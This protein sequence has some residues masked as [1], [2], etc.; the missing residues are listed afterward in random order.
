M[1]IS[2]FVHSSVHNFG[3][4]KKT[5]VAQK[6]PMDTHND[7]AL[8]EQYLHAWERISHKRACTFLYLSIVQ[9]KILGWWRKLKLLRRVQWILTMI[10]TL[11]EQYLHAWE[12]ISH[13]RAC[14]FLYLALVFKQCRVWG[15][16]IKLK[17]LRWVKCIHTMI[18]ALLQ[19]YLHAWKHNAHKHAW[20]FLYLEIIDEQCRI[21]DWRR[22]CNLLGRVQCN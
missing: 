10:F 8:L 19:Q 7:F 9:C 20:T 17:L 5:K 21:F 22:K 6:G 4:M 2:I 12:R 11:L 13:K 3:M 18:F 16:W 1:Y 14:T 15:R